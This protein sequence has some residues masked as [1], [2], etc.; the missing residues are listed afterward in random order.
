MGDKIM[1]ALPREIMD[2]QL[3]AIDLMIAMYPDPL[4]LSIPELDA[5]IVEQLRVW[6]EDETFIPYSNRAA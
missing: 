2:L 5:N 4:E 3:S 6:C 1:F